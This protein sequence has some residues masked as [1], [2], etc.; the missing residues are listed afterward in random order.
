[1][2]MKLNGES[3]VAYIHSGMD[4]VERNNIKRLPQSRFIYI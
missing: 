1:M 3:Q 4:E 2:Q